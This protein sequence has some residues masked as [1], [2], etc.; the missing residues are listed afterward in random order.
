MPV[1]VVAVDL[2]AIA[3]IVFAI[4]RTVIRRRRHPEL[5]PTPEAVEEMRREQGHDKLMPNSGGN[6]MSR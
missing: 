5:P 1:Y 4:T 6:G 2:L 3:V